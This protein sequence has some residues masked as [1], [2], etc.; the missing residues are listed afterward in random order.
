[1]DYFSEELILLNQTAS[2]QEEA[3][4]LLTDEFKKKNLVEE[5]FH[6]SIIKRE[7][8]FPTGLQVK[9]AGIAIPHTDSDKVKKTQLGF[10]SL[11][12][13]VLFSDMGDK[14]HKIEI[15]M[16]FMLGLKETHEQ[17]A[18]LQKLMGVFQQEELVSRLLNC[19]SKEEFKQI[20]NEAGL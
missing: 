13:P 19:N 15:N 2:T 17:L 12:E 1:M 8:S 3:L 5:D 16:I 11:K 14:K 20:I 9:G 10:L 18:M 4:K 6:E 7:E